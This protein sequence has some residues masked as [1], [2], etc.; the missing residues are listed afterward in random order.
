MELETEN[1]AAEEN[2]YAYLERDFSSENFKIEI[3]NLP[4]YY[5]INEFRKLLNDKL[6][7]NSN[8][9]KTTK[10][11]CPFAYVCFR[12]NEDRENA[13]NVLSSYVWKGKEL[14]VLKAKP[15]PDPLVKKRK[16]C[17]DQQILKKI[18]PES[19]RKD[20]FE[21]TQEEKLKFKTIPYWNIDYKD[22][23]DL[24]QNSIRKLLKKLANDLAHHNPELQE[25]IEKQKNLHNGLVC[26]LSDIRYAE[27]TTGY[28]NKC[29]F[30]VGIDE[31]TKLPTVGFRI[32][33]Y[34]NGTIGV[35]PV[36]DLIHISNP[37]K[38]AVK[39]FENFVRCSKLSVFN[40]EFHTGHF[41]QLM[42]R[43]APNQLMLVVGI[44][45]QNLTDEE[46]DEFKKN[47]IDFFS[48]G[49]GKEAN[50]TSLYYQKIVKKN[51]NDDVTQSEHLWG[52]THIYENILGLKFKISPEAFFQVNSKG[53]EV[54]YQTAMELSQ[55]LENSTVLDVCCGTGTI[56]L[57]FSKKC[58]Q[59]L[60]IEIISQ[61]V[62]DA[63]ENAAINNVENA[64]FFVGKAE[65]ILGTV[66]YKS[67]ENNVIAVVDP[68]RAGLHKQAV[69]QIRK[70]PKINKMVYVSCNPMAAR[71]NFIDFGK[72]ESK[73]VHGDPLIPTKAVAVDM[74]PYTKHCELV[75]CFERW[76]G[77]KE[78]FKKVTTLEKT[79]KEEPPC[80]DVKNE[81]ENIK[82]ENEMTACK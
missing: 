35:A 11:N 40:P 72:S 29:E 36:D 8:K 2:P 48:V 16:E 37:M 19:V 27:E 32:G 42:V 33:S 41:R 45:P 61:A 47:L 70:I 57:C 39:V 34:V 65:D 50:V 21:G 1:A 67:Q 82:C 24:K 64:E 4:K 38:S 17:S 69:L 26:E 73:K 52:V 76:S 78:Q 66:C 58:K 68:P 13:I 63:K 49:D 44:H 62:D 56:G 25:W 71:E 59:V 53:A 12:N 54:L 7:L 6:K 28:R 15:A 81:I 9:I 30:T 14:K 77:I 20:E 51:Q 75:I 5:G 31:E 74:F 55:P 22:Q 79:L 80:D 23:L 46:L 60:G 3:K 10:R 18:K 43:S